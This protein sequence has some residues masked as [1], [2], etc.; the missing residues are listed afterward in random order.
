MLFCISLT[1]LVFR[2]FLSDFKTILYKKFDS[3]NYSKYDSFINSIYLKSTRY[4][5]YSNKLSVK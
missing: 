5:H 2:I 4:L 1:G 3:Q